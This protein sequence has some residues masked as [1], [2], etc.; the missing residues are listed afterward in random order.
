MAY[1]KKNKETN[2][3][4]ISKNVD[5]H[6]NHNK[7]DKCIKNDIKSFI[8]SIPKKF[9]ILRDGDNNYRILAKLKVQS[10]HPNA[11]KKLFKNL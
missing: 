4:V 6:Q 5:S 1:R 8:E 2:I 9:V 7:V 10:P 11:I 3:S